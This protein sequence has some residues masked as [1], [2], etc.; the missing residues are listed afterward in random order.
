MENKM[1][2]LSCC[3]KKLRFRTNAESA[4][5]ADPQSNNNG[6]GVPDKP[7]SSLY[8]LAENNPHVIATSLFSRKHRK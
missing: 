5:S 7:Q 3:F 8:K 4:A 2:I 6:D 1:H